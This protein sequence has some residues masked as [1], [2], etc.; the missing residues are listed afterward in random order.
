MAKIKTKL[1]PRPKVQVVTAGV[2]VPLSA[3]PTQT[4][5]VMVQADP[6]NGGNI[7]L[8]AAGVTAG[9][10]VL[11]E[12]GKSFEIVCEDTLADEDTVYVDLSEIF[13]D[14]GTAGDS[15]FVAELVLESVRYQGG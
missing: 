8:G 9:Q 6:S 1:V 4:F 2:P 10:C 5:A 15:V 11:L 7:F 14:A 13:I 12:P 3:V